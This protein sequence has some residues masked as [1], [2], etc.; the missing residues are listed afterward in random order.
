MERD[1]LATLAEI[2]AIKA[3]LD[4]VSNASPDAQLGA[5]SKA[6]GKLAEIE[7]KR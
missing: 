4:K 2:E 7:A 3:D 5:A 6:M 1:A